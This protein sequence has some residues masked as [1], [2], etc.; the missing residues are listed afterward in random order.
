MGELW[1]NHLTGIMDA[2]LSGEK[3]IKSVSVSLHETLECPTG[4]IIPKTPKYKML[5]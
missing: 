5:E 2:H 1:T 4:K 3:P